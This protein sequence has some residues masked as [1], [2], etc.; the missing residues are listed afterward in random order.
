MSIDDAR[1]EDWDALRGG[2]HKVGRDGRFTVGLGDGYRITV[3]A[4][5]SIF[6]KGF[7][8]IDQ[9]KQKPKALSEQA[10]LNAINNELSKGYGNASRAAKIALYEYWLDGY[11]IDYK[12]TSGHWTT[13][14]RDYFLFQLGH[15]YRVSDTLVQPLINWSHVHND[16]QWIAQDASGLCYL[17][18]VE[19]RINGA[20]WSTGANKM[21]GASSF[22]SF[23][24]G[25][26]DWKLLKFKRPMVLK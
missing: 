2:E 26:G 13:L 1:P 24:P 5:D 4:D 23:K 18:A 12:A 21:V 22:A 7:K 11:V 17:Y 14:E 16:F 15:I 9:D 19:P 3:P 20:Q 8:M 25:R 6:I 10:K